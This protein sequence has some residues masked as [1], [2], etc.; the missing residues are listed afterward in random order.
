MPGV[1]ERIYVYA[2]DLP[3]NDLYTYRVGRKKRAD[4][5]PL[6]DDPVMGNVRALF[7]ES[8]L[9]LVAL[10]R[11]MGYSDKI[12]RQSV[13]Q[14]L[15]SRDPRLSML[16]RFAEAMDVTVEELGVKGKKMKRK[17]EEELAAGG[18]G[19][20]PSAFRDLLLDQKERTSPSWTVDELVCHPD[21]A[22]NYCDAVRVATDAPRL[23]DDL[24]LRTLMNIRRSH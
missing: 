15:R 14:F 7:E 20:D 8:G 18:C 12:A 2:L 17:L 22:K 24:I 1:N 4:R 13:W 21:D 10:G 5:K 16:R 6:S 11:R 9:S 23:P 19:L 3:V